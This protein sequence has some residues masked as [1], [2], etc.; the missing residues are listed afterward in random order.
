MDRALAVAD[1]ANNGARAPTAIGPYRVT[2]QKARHVAARRRECCR[3]AGN[4]F[5]ASGEIPFSSERSYETVHPTPRT[6]SRI[7]YERRARSCSTMFAGTVSTP[8]PWRRPRSERPAGA[9]ELAG[10][11]GRT[12]AVAYESFPRGAVADTNHDAWQ[13][14]VF[15]G[16]SAFDPPRDEARERSRKRQN[17]VDHDYRRSSKTASVIA[18]HLARGEERAV[19][20]SDLEGPRT[21]PLADVQGRVVTP[22]QSG[23]QS[24]DREGLQGGRRRCNDGDGLTIPRP[25]L[26]PTSCGDWDHGYGVSKQAADMGAR[27]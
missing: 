5:P 23:T 13:D 14:L 7:V 2:R 1:R 21:L 10:R 24:A 22:C 19:T 3:N 25:S 12:L 4:T 17:T 6:R 15:A 9:E 16:P 26:W 8:T 27:R 18:L 20:G 11:A